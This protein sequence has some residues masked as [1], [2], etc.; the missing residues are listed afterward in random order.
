[1]NF[2][3][4][5]LHPWLPTVQFG[6][7]VQ[8]AQA[9]A[10]HGRVPVPS[11][12]RRSMTCT[13]ATTASTRAGRVRASCLTGTTARY[14]ASAFRGASASSSSACRLIA[15][16]DDGTQSFTDRKDFNV[17]GSIQPFAQIKNKWISGLTFGVRQLVL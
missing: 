7:E 16:G 3:A 6:M 15:E 1:M 2:H 17:Y 4:E 12:R 5:D 14:P 11:A 13:P 10:W 9:A 8:N